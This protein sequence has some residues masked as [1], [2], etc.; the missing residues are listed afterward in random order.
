MVKN[1]DGSIMLTWYIAFMALY[2]LTG[3]QYLHLHK[4]SKEKQRK[5]LRRSCFRMGAKLKVS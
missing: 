1:G 2:V 5:S 4:V 3:D